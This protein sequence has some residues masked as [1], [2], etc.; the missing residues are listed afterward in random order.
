MKSL[1]SSWISGWH[2]PITTCLGF[3]PIV[4]RNRGHTIHIT[5]FAVSHVP[6][7]KPVDPS[8]PFKARLLDRWRDCW[9]GQ[10]LSLRTEVLGQGKYG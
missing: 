9:A 4:M 5:F 6:S 1:K 3:R 7:R 10:G 8:A 2:H